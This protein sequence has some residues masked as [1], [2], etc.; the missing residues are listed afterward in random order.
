MGNPFTNLSLVLPYLGHIPNLKCS[1]DD[2]EFWFE[3]S[4]EYACDS[5]NNILYDVD[6]T[7]YSTLNNWVVKFDLVCQPAMKIAMF[8][9]CMF[10]ANALSTVTLMKLGDIIGRRKMVGITNFG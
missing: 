5:E 3:C 7:Q 10:I 4:Q 6:N 9:F 1:L 8:G 2:G